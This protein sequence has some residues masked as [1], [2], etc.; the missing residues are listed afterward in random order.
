MP[1]LVTTVL[2]VMIVAVVLMFCMCC[3]GLCGVVNPFEQLS[4]CRFCAQC[5]DCGRVCGWSRNN[6]EEVE[7]EV[8]KPK[9]S[10]PDETLKDRVEALEEGRARDSWAYRPRPPR[11]QMRQWQQFVR[12]EPTPPQRSFVQR[13]RI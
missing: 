12:Q 6:Q 5:C 11:G 9:G 7:V 2:I 3:F 13:S 1:A 10:S 8:V 4:Q